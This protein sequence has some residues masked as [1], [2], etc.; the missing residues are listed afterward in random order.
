MALLCRLLEAPNDLCM[1]ALIEEDERDAFKTL[2]AAGAL[3]PAQNAAPAI[4]CPD[5][6]YH[7]VLPRQ[8]GNKLEGLCPECGYVALGSQH[9]QPMMPDID[10]VLSR[11]RLAL[12]VAA[13]QDSMPLIANSLW[14][15]GDHSEGRRRWRVLLARHLSKP[16]NRTG[17]RRSLSTHVERDNGIIIGTAS[18]SMAGID[19]LSLPYVHL[20]ELFRWRSGKFEMDDSLWKWCRKPA[21]LRDHAKNSIFFD[22]YRVAI[23][24]GEEYTFS[25][26]QA[27]FWEY[28]FAA[29]GGKR[30]KSVIMSHVES[31]Q[32]NPRELFRHNAK[33]MEAFDILVNCN[34]E[35]FYWLIV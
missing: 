18:R 32:P 24:D 25:Q 31:D 3:I 10:W 22:D 17:F 26:K 7:D 34:E 33:Q 30:H 14:K 16:E 29:K 21:H 1:E 8:D 9:T 28:V 2:K 12:G 23:L 6:Q 19:D 13:R 5:C 35:G 20:G 15:V 27:L 11:I 4:L